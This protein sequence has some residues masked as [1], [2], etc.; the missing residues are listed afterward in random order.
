MS[1]NTVLSETTSVVS[2]E[3]FLADFRIFARITDPA[4]MGLANLFA[5]GEIYSSAMIICPDLKY[6]YIKN[7]V[8]ISLYELYI[9]K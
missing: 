1:G 4:N 3:R 7:I 2:S 8:I 6:N 5:P 9:S